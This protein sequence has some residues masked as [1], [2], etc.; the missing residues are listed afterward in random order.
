[1]VHTHTVWSLSCAQYVVQIVNNELLGGELMS[2]FG[3]NQRGQQVYA[4]KVMR[5]VGKDS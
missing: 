2:K 4:P 1:M 3:L 5:F